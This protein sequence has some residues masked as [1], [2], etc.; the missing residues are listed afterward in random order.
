MKPRLLVIGASG[1]V[2][3]RWAQVASGQFEV[4]GG[5]RNPPA[6]GNWVPIDITDPNSVR[7][8]FDQ[9]RPRAVTHLAALSDIDRCERE[10]ELAERINTQGTHHVAEACARHGAHL[11]YTSTDAVF[12]GTRGYYRELDPPTPPNWY[13]QTKARAEQFVQQLLPTACIVR[14]SLVLGTSARDAGNSYLEKVIVSCREKRP[15]IS[16]DYEYRNPIDV[17]TLCTFFAELTGNP[18]AAGIV[19][20]GATDKISRYDLALAIAT[21]LGAEPALVVRQTEPVPGR[22][23]RGADD[24]LA[25]ERVGQLCR[26]PVPNCQ[27]VIERALDGVA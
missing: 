21:R 20:I 9:V 10:Q 4:I 23:P 17:H 7:A 12:D 18:E 22:A 2:G 14:V 27:Q 13:G 15:I 16:P 25:T 3:A 5:A 26:T 8:A 6:D 24:F 1:F 11:L 19:H